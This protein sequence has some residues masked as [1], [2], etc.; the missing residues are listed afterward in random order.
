[1]KPYIEKL[2][3]LVAN[4]HIDSELGFSILNDEDSDYL[5]VVINAAITATEKANLQALN[6]DVPVL[7]LENGSIVRKYRNGKTEWV[8]NMSDLEDIAPENLKIK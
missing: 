4:G 3:S 6:S 1:M 7:I 5:G 2:A 8:K